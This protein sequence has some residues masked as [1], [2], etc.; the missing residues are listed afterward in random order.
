MPVVID[1]DYN[2]E[3]T[4]HSYVNYCV[5]ASEVDSKLWNPEFQDFVLCFLNC[6]LV[7][8]FNVQHRQ[9]TNCNV[10]NFSGP[11]FLSILLVLYLQ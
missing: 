2:D 6:V 3:Q 11:Y 4:E 8:N 9:S 7:V 5:G 1:K 10:Y